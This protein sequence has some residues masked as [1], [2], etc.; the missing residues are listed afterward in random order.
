MLS[1]PCVAGRL[2]QCWKRHIMFILFHI[3]YQVPRHTM[4]LGRARSTSTASRSHHTHHASA[5]GVPEHLF[6][7]NDAE[8]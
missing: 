3:V 6:D 1:M 8:L 2:G 4:M 5:H 7:A